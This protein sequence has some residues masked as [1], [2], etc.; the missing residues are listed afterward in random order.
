M[1]TAIPRSVF[2]EP[3]RVGGQ[4]ERARRGRAAV[5]HVGERDAGEAE[6]RDD[7]VRVV[8]L[9]AAAERELDVA[10]LQRLRR[11]ARAGSRPRPC[12]SPTRP[13]KRPNG[14]RPTPTMATSVIV[15]SPAATG[16]G[17]RTSRPRCRRR[18]CGTAPTRAPSPCP[19]AST[20]GS[21]S[22][23]RALDLHLARQL[24]VADAER[25]EVACRSGPRR[26]A[27][28]AGSLASSTPRAC[29]GARSRCSTIAVDAQRGHESWAGNVTMPQ[30]VQRLPI[31]CGSSLGN[32]KIRS[33]TGTWAITCSIRRVP[34]TGTRLEGRRGRASVNS[35]ARRSRNAATPSRASGADAAASNSAESTRCASAGDATVIMRHTSW[36]VSATETGA[37]PRTSSRAYSVAAPDDIVGD[38]LYEAGALCASAARNAPPRDEP[39]ERGRDAD[40]SGQEPRRARLRDDAE[41]GEHEAET[42]GRAPRTAR[43]SP[44]SSTRRHLPPGRS[45]PRSRAWCRRRSAARPR[46]RDR[47]RSTGLPS[48]RRTSVRPHRDRRLRRR[49]GPDPVTTTARTSGSASTRSN[50]SHS[51]R[52]IR[53]VNAFSV[54]GRCKR[55]AG[56]TVGIGRVVSDRLVGSRSCVVPIARAARP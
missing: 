6:Q 35:G 1:P 28:A 50:A 2:A 21:D 29:R 10:P 11:P 38:V 34:T 9:V 39:V 36:R 30:S 49:P 26:A 37:V 23:S 3:D 14:C 40:E 17:T 15:L 27:T 52:C 12:R 55:D 46:R 31:N 18:R 22:V 41:P 5:V 25:H 13:A 8:D 54:S 32:V 20:S 16:D 45:P 33:A 24:D 7:R 51:S 43:P 19:G 48:R 4:R 56:D 44:A 47:G 42:R 53:L